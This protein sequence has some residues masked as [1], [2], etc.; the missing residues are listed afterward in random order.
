MTRVGERLRG[1][2][3]ASTIDGLAIRAASKLILLIAIRTIYVRSVVNR[4][5]LSPSVAD[6]VREKSN[7]NKKPGA[8]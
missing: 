4:A 5:A 6:D 7:K 2:R 8:F 1:T 3:T